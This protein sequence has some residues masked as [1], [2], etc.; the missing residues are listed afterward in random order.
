MKKVFTCGGAS[1]NSVITLDKFPEDKA[2]TIHKCDFDETLGNT[3][4]GKA[5][6]LSR[7]GFH[8]TFH[9]LIGDDIYGHSVKKQLDLPNLYLTTDIDPRGTE[10]HLN[11]MNANGE[12][13]SIFINPSSDQPDLDFD[14][15]ERIIFH[16]DYSIINISNYCRYL[17]PICKKLKKDIWTDLHDYN[18]GNT[19]HQ[20]FI[21]SA[22]YI[23][24]SSDNLP[25][26]EDFMFEQVANGK[27]LVVCTHAKKGAS[28]L[29]ASGQWFD[30]PIVDEYQM[31]NTNGAGDSFFSGYLY[32]YDKGFDTFTCLQYATITAGLCISSKTLSFPDLNPE[33]IETEFKKYYS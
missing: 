32:A 31:I 21:N 18:R 33:I 7:L 12:R 22:D 26:Y 19:Y 29:N 24:L 20:D 27:K 30:I 3:G 17:L 10:R 11:I 23:F 15:F 8:T 2:Q 16:A 28:A 6:A 4:A 13:I 5:L 9:S 25:D 1:W 14:F